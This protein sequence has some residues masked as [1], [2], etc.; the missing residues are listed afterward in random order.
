MR[1]APCALNSSS[2]PL[3]IPPSSRAANV[4]TV[5]AKFHRELICPD[6]ESCWPMVE[7]RP[8]HALHRNRKQNVPSS[9]LASN[10]GSLTGR[11][12]KVANTAADSSAEQQE[13]AAVAHAERIPV[14][15][16]DAEGEGEVGRNARPQA[17][18]R[19]LVRRQVQLVLEHERERNDVKAGRGRGEQERHDDRAGVEK[20]PRALFNRR[21][22]R[23][24]CGG[25]LCDQ[26]RWAIHAR[27]APGWDRSVVERSSAAARANCAFASSFLPGIDQR[28][29]PFQVQP[30]PVGG[31]FLGFRELR[32]RQVRLVLRHQRLAP[33]FQRIGEV[34]AFLVGERELRDGAV[35][36]ALRQ[37]HLRPSR[38][39]RRESTARQLHGA[40]EPA[41]GAAPICSP[42][43]RSVPRARRQ[44]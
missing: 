24:G 2:Q 4:A 28:L 35:G 7:P 40:G 20:N 14:V 30:A 42:A 11:N 1:I 10:T 9:A 31:V 25:T 18:R 5:P 27:A 38:H 39:R 37:Q 34:R 8:F 17:E 12:A 29:A 41:I 3:R 21:A 44:S 15:A 36:V 33:A 43:P 23:I 19:Q 6:I 22:R 26:M 13:V 16:H 32:Q